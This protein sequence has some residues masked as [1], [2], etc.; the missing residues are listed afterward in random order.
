MAASSSNTKDVPLVYVRSDRAN[1]FEFANRWLLGSVGLSRYVK[2]TGSTEACPFK[3]VDEFIQKNLE[4][5]VDFPERD[6]NASEGT[7][8]N[9]EINL[10]ST[11][12]YEKIV[13]RALF[14]R[15]QEGEPRNSPV[16]GKGENELPAIV[17]PNSVT[18]VPVSVV[19]LVAC[20]S[21]VVDQNPKTW[22]LDKTFY[23][24]R[25]TFGA[26]SEQQTSIGDY[27][28]VK[29]RGKFC[30]VEELW[31]IL[32]NKFFV[33]TK[34]TNA[35][36]TV[37]VHPDWKMTDIVASFVRSSSEHLLKENPN[38]QSHLVARYDINGTMYC[39]VE[40]YMV[41]ELITAIYAK[42]N[43]G[44]EVLQTTRDNFI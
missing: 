11:T 23:A 29:L 32:T 33:L 19:L 17:N 6:I 26:L 8:V 31:M 10:M 13:Q 12:A 9:G 22:N 21:A 7:L 3:L 25:K 38:A 2:K 34:P 43:Y 42:L 37:Y 44:V 39:K 27:W 35:D 30:S 14:S 18:S 15:F 16:L 20:I 5:F 1:I 4:F 24:F 28:G 41:G 40:S 36:N